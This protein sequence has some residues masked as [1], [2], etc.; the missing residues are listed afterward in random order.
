MQTTRQQSAILKFEMGGNKFSAAADGVRSHAPSLQSHRGTK[1]VWPDFQPMR[2]P[3][4]PVCIDIFRQNPVFTSLHLKS[5]VHV[6]RL[7]ALQ[8]MWNNSF[9]KIIALRSIES[10]DDHRQ[11]MAQDEKKMLIKVKYCVLKKVREPLISGSWKHW[12]KNRR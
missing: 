6:H 8:P 2:V 1:V 4:E 12:S 9:C 5:P 11:I 10:G 7:R 3:E